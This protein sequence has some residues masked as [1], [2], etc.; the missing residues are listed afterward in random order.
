MEVEMY[1]DEIFH[2]REANKEIMKMPRQAQEEA[3]NLKNELHEAITE[4]K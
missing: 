3:S 2:H 4:S 1:K